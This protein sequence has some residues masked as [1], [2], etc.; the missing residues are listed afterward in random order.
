MTTRLDIWQQGYFWC[1]LGYLGLVSRYSCLYQSVHI[2]A[3]SLLQLG[4]FTFISAPLLYWSHHSFLQLFKLYYF[5]KFSVVKCGRTIQHML[6]FS[7]HHN[8][9]VKEISEDA[10]PLMCKYLVVSFLLIV[11]SC[12]CMVYW[13]SYLGSRHQP[14][15]SRNRFLSSFF[16]EFANWCT[17]CKSVVHLYGMETLCYSKLKWKYQYHWCDIIDLSA[18]C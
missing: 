16:C 3:S 15:N 11:V 2:L 10:V 6:Q 7:H 8:L 13:T 1:F 4:G 9:V 14:S 18:S 12:M 5:G 17:R